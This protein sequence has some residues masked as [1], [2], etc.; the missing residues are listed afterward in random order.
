MLTRKY[1][2]CKSSVLKFAVQYSYIDYSLKILLKLIFAK[3][4]SSV[5]RYNQVNP[6]LCYAFFVLNPLANLHHFFSVAL[7]FSV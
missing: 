7:S 2:S 4:V 6:L 1:N 5:F 3:N